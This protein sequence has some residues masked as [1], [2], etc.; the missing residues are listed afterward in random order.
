M[1]N[2]KAWLD[3]KEPDYNE[4]IALLSKH[5]K[6]RILIQGLLRKENPGKVRYELT[7]VLMMHK[8]PGGLSALIAK[9]PKEEK[10]ERTTDELFALVIGGKKEEL[11]YFEAKRLLDHLKIVPKSRSKVD[12]FEALDPANFKTEPGTDLESQKKNAPVG[13]TEP[14]GKIRL[15]VVRNLKDNEIKYGDLPVRLQKLWDANT[16]MYKKCRSIHEK[17]KL[18]EKASDADRQPL[19]AEMCG[20]DD[21]IRANWGEIDSWDGKPETPG[22]TEKVDVDHKRINTNRKYIST[23]KEKLAELIKN[24]DEQGTAKLRGKIQERVSELLQAKESFTDTYKAE[25]QTLGITF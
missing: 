2:I 5:C 19:V 20:M 24:E 21:Q 1:E 14:T 10:K 17:L 22:T 4:G 12:V 7:K 15:K 11:D 8:N 25:L 3:S 18:M 6:N 16:D 13:E 23:N 9:A